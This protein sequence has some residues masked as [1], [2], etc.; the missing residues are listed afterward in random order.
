MWND[1]TLDPLELV[2]HLDLPPSKVLV[3]TMTAD[4]VLL[5]WDQLVAM[6]AMRKHA[7]RGG[8]GACHKQRQLREFCFEND[9]REVDLSSSD[10]NWRLLLKTMPCLYT[11]TVIGPGV[12][13]FAFRLL[14]DIDWNYHGMHDKHAQD[15]G[16]RH[17]FQISCANGHQWHVHFHR[18]GSCDLDHVPHRPFTE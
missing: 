5:S 2:S 4:P 15:V 12:V 17:V 7:G 10:Y 18:R 6:P 11:K 8:K 3:L 16:E 9:I 1:H 14:D 13:K